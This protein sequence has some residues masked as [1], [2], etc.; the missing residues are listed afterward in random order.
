MQ[1]RHSY[2]VSWPKGASWSTR[3]SRTLVAN[4]AA[5]FPSSGSRLLENLAT[6]ATD[7]SISETN[8]ASNWEPGSQ[9]QEQAGSH[10][11]QHP[12][13]VGPGAVEGTSSVEQQVETARGV[14]QHHQQHR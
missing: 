5:R 14:H 12:K 10:R 9:C 3:A 13:P 7:P 4:A 6:C 11:G 2:W 8:N 1:T